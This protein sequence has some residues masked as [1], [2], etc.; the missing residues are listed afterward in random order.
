MDKVNQSTMFIVGAII[1]AGLII[2][3]A[4][5]YSNNPENKNVVGVVGIE[6]NDIEEDVDIEA[7]G[8]DNVKEV[9]ADD[10]IVGSVNS[11]VKLIEFSDTECPYCKKF[12]LSVK[13]LMDE[14]KDGNQVAWVY[15]H[16]PLDALHSKARL[17][18]EATE[19]AN[20]LGGN[21]KF[22]DY[23]NTLYEITPSNNQFDMDKLPEIAKQIGLD[24]DEFN[25]CFKER[26]YKDKVQSH[27][28]DAI[29]S[30]ARGTP[31]SILVGPNGEKVV[32]AGAEPIEAIRAKIES[33]LG[34]I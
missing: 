23:I 18:A 19:C 32:I 12:H 2:G 21:E 5:V 29:N 6:E 27:L 31:Y 1:V 4:V 25:K 26:R 20:E 16:F 22:W 3:G 34:L 14:Y 13:E 8:P 30:G 24:V 28:D 9:T 11:L 17:E 33:L 10:H 15:R 7:P